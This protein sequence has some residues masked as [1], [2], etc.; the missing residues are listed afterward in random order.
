MHKVWAWHLADWLAVPSPG[1]AAAAGAVLLLTMALAP[2]LRDRN[3]AESPTAH[4]LGRAASWALALGL[5]YALEL[6]APYTG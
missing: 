2:F 1:P 5:G 6:L 4:I 3:P